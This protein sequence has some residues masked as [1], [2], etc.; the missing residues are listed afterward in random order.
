MPYILLLPLSFV[1][2]WITTLA[3]VNRVP[4]DIPEAESELVAGYHT[5][6]SGFRWALFFMAEYGSLFAASAFG[7]VHLP[8]RGQR[9]VPAGARLDVPQDEPAGASWPCG[10]AGRC[11]ASAPTS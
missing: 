6:Y 1:I 5:E 10:C 3:E 11:P 7:A 8:G 2:Y 4:F 9:P